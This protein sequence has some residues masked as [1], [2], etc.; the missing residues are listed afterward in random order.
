MEAEAG[1]WL[2][3][4]R[5]FFCL[6]TAQDILKLKYQH[7]I[8][9][10]EQ[11]SRMGT[12]P[13]MFT[14]LLENLDFVSK[15][16]CLNFDEA[17]FIVT[18]GEPDKS[19]KIFRSEYS[20]CH[21]VRLRCPANTSCAIFSATLP[22]KIMNRILDSL[23]VPHGP[24]KTCVI[25]LSTNRKNLCFSVRKLE[26]SLSSLGNLDFLFP[27]SLHPPLALPKKT[28][29]F[30]T[31]TTMAMSVEARLKCRLPPGMVE[32]IH[33]SRSDLSKT[34]ITEDFCTSTGNIL[35]LVATSVISNVRLLLFNHISVI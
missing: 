27:V 2:V 1:T 35:V 12:E 26:A 21:E 6:I 15:I 23:R 11:C 9:S 29:I 14:Q 31:T 16:K 34:R 3:Q 5:G 17:H 8:I 30:V 28:I 13:P 7:I 10:P 33:A 25:S 24:P 22:P 32:R 4:S 19:G 18:S 20:K